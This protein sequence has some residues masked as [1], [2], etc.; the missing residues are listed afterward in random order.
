M[1]HYVFLL[2][3]LL[4][5]N[6]AFS[7][8]GFVFMITFSNLHVSFISVKILLCLGHNIKFVVIIYRLLVF[9]N[10]ILIF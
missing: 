6:L 9:S 5:S 3:S 8:C 2:P 4:L 10:V 1:N 7:S